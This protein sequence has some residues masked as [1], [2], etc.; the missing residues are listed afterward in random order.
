MQE[1]IATKPT[2]QDASQKLDLIKANI[3]NFMQRI[4]F[5]AMTGSDQLYLMNHIF[6]NK[7]RAAIA[8]GNLTAAVTVA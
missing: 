5:N 3:L 2:I 7:E 4:C 6:S 1:A 8:S